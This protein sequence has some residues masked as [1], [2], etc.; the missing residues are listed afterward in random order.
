MTKIVLVDDD[1]HVR[2]SLE[3]LLESAG[4][5]F[6]SYPTGE[7]LLQENGWLDCDCLVLDVRMSGMTG[8]EVQ[9]ELSKMDHVPPLVFLSAQTDP[10]TIETAISGGATLFLS[11]PF[12]DDELLAA[13]E[14]VASEQGG[15]KKDKD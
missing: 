7:D 13:L 6:R 12:D 9:A 8:L 10:D 4:F 3:N 2:E 11:K 1:D 15:M 14:R 5:D